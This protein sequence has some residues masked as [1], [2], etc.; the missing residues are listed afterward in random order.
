M[1]I[2]EMKIE[3]IKVGL[4]IKSLVS[5]RQGTI[6]ECDHND[7]NFS[8]IHWDGDDQP[9]S[10]FYGNACECEVIA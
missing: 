7:D 2:N 10:G 9:Y 8:W 5:D 6:V 3:D 4:R 1:R